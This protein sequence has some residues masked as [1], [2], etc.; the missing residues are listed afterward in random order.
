M[1]N[2]IAIPVHNEEGSVRTVLAQVR[3]VTGDCIVIID[4]GSTDGSVEVALEAGDVDI[5]HHARNEGYGRSLIDAFVYAQAH[6][7]ETV[8]TLDCDEQHDPAL[9]PRFTE[10]V[11]GFDIVSGTRYAPDSPARGE[12]PADR[13]QINREITALVAE[14]TGYDLTDAFCGYKAYT[15][16]ALGGLHLTEDGYA[17]PLQ[18]WIQ[19]ARAG[20]T[21]TELAVPR[22]Y[23]D[24]DRGFGRDLDHPERRL[25]YYRRVIDRELA[26]GTG[27][28]VE[29]D[30]H[31]RIGGRAD[32]S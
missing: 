30:G 21:V 7:F 28:S 31:A 16:A 15:V 8:V 26:R 19:A 25:H 14:V 13:Q 3:Q 24:A 6:R 23:H 27:E 29:R 18:V 10:L 1:A 32:R 12:A 11:R 20:L 22:I 9:I 5:V 17:L 2:L 4:D